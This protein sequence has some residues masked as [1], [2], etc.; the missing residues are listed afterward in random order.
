MLTL[1][2]SSVRNAISS[3][4]RWGHTTLEL[5]ITSSESAPR[6]NLLITSSESFFEPSDH[7]VRIFACFH[8]RIFSIRPFTI[9]EPSH[10]KPCSPP[11]HRL[12][13]WD[14][15]REFGNGHQKRNTEGADFFT[16]CQTRIFE[17]QAQYP[18][19]SGFGEIK[20]GSP[21][22]RISWRELLEPYEIWWD[23]HGITK[24]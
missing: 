24:A 4:I 21:E 17:Y 9:F 18:R 7:L 22:D 19:I 5:L 3:N 15:T 1:S 6:P 20:A 14:I 13:L 2:G 16:A 8:C 10:T 12:G 11:P 23:R